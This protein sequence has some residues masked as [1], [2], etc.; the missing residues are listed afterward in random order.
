MNDDLDRRLLDGI[1]ITTDAYKAGEID[2]LRDAQRLAE[3]LV[4][5]LQTRIS[6]LEAER[7]G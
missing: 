7:A 1:K 2:A 5:D 3:Q 4:R 6:A